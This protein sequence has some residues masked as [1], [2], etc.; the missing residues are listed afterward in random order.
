MKLCFIEKIYI[1]NNTKQ[2]VCSLEWVLYKDNQ[3]SVIEIFPAYPPLYIYA[4]IYIYRS[5]YIIYMLLLLEYPIGE[6]VSFQMSVR[7]GLSPTLHKG[8]LIVI[9][10]VPTGVYTLALI[11]C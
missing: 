6:G 3:L 8:P 4:Y 10:T 11:S 1:I 7:L 9:Q 2:T 5:T